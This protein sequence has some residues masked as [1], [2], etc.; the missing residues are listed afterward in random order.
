MNE[1][2]AAVPEA[3]IRADVARA[4]DEDLGAIDLTAQLLP[5]WQQ[6][7][8]VIVCREPAVL[9]GAAWATRAFLSLDPAMAL[10]WQ[11]ADGDHVAAGA[12]LL[13]L[14]GRARAIFSAERTAL[15]FL[16]TL[17]ATATLTRRYV[18][19]IAGSK[20]RVLDTRKTLPGLRLAQKYAVRVGGGCNHRL[21][22]YDAVL[23]KENHIL[24]AGSITKA[25]TAARAIAGTRMVEIE[26][27]SLAEF[28]QAIKARPDRIMLDEL[29][30]AELDRAVAI[31]QGRVELEISGGVTLAQIRALAD[32][33]VDYISVGALTKNIQAID[34]SLRVVW[35]HRADDH[36]NGRVAL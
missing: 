5:A 9:C 7:E 21:G 23:I 13:R 35:T 36:R 28:E 31:N 3:H 16:Q 10:D 22:L 1:A 26:V 8:A 11:Q 14:R 29:P 25:I 2:V 33:G 17:S 6:A 15:N 24:A 12:T 20:T 27:E 4:L 19:A 34:L 32:L 30:P 18:E